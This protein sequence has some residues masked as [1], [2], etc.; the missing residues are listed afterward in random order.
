M[1]HTWGGHFRLQTIEV[2]ARAMAA[3]F[4]RYERNGRWRAGQPRVVAMTPA[5]MY[6]D[7]SFEMLLLEDNGDLWQKD[8]PVYVRGK[9]IGEWQEP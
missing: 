5:D 8:S 3:A 7:G 2:K 4:I 6:G 1:H 9:P